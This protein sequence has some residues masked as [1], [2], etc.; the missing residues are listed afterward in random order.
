MAQWTLRGLSAERGIDA[1]NRL[2][3]VRF[4]EALPLGRRRLLA[5]VQ[6]RETIE[7]PELVVLG[8]PFFEFAGISCFSVLL[9]A[10]VNVIEPAVVARVRDLN[11]KNLR[12]LARRLEGVEPVSFGKVLL[13]RPRKDSSFVA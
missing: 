10:E 5:N 12:P 13:A 2:H 9:P 4:R 7:H 6:L 1:D 11:E 8:K 3:P